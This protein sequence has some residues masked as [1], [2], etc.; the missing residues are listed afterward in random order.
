MGPKCECKLVKQLSSVGD[1][2]FRGLFGC[3]V[4]GFLVRSFSLSYNSLLKFCSVSSSDS[5]YLV[6]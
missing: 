4:C 6:P 3:V 5:L 2:E 1:F